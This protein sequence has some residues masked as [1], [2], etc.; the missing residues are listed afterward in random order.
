MRTKVRAINKMKKLLPLL[1]TLAII[2]S[3]SKCKEETEAVVDKGNGTL[4]MNFKAKLNE[5]AF[6][7]NKIYDLNGK[8]VRFS[9]FSFFVSNIAASTSSASTTVNKSVTLIDFKDILDSVKAAKGVTDIVSNVVL[10]NVQSI[11]FGLGVALDLNKKTP[12]DYPSTN[13]LSESGAYW[14]DWN[15]YIF[16]KF[17]GLVDNNN[18]G[19]FETGF[20][21][22]TGGNDAYRSTS[23]N[24]SL[25]IAN[26]K[27]AVN[28]E[29]DINKLFT[30]VNMT[31]F[32]G[33]DASIKV[34]MDNFKIA[35]VLR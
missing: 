31:Q 23:F 6:I 11:G 29:L 3:S 7:M 5:Q 17:D 14:T 33:D 22:E 21:I 25:V 34:V 19:I 12:K 2:N 16:C 24:K 30:G 9:R 20:A 4:E 27:A 15:S 28:F 1:L 10:E 26:Q 13:P 18:D 35:L 32:A 8:K